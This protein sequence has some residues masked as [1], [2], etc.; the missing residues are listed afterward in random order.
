MYRIKRLIFSGLMTIMI[1]CLTIAGTLVTP[2][3]EQVRTPVAAETGD[4]TPASNTCPLACPWRRSM[5][6]DSW[7]TVNLT[8]SNFTEPVGVGSEAEITV[9]AKSRCDISNVTV[10]IVLSEAWP[11]VYPKGISF[12]DGSSSR[13]WMVNLQANISTSFTERIKAF[14]TGFG[15]IE[16]TARWWN[17]TPPPFE[18]LIPPWVT[19]ENLTAIPR[20]EI[21]GNLSL[22]IWRYENMSGGYPSIEALPPPEWFN[23]SIK[24]IYLNESIIMTHKNYTSHQPPSPRFLYESKDSSL[25]LV[26]NDGILVTEMPIPEPPVYLL[27][28]LSNFTEP[29]G[30]G[31]ET[32][33]TVFLI[34]LVD[35]QNVSAQIILPEGLSFISGNLTWSG[36]LKTNLRTRFSARIRAEKTGNWTIAIGTG[37]YLADG[38]WF[39]DAEVYGVWWYGDAQVLGISVYDA[40]IMRWSGN[41]LLSPFPIGYHYRTYTQVYPGSKSY[42]E[43]AAIEWSTD[44]HNINDTLTVE[45]RI[46]GVSDLA[47]IQFYVKWDPTV[48]R[49]LC[50]ESGDFLEALGYQSIWMKSEKEIDLG[51]I[52]ASHCLMPPIVSGVGITTPNSG[53]V[54]TLIFQVI[55]FTEGTEI[56][57]SSDPENSENYWLDSTGSGIHHDFEFMFPAHFSFEKSI[58]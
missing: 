22:G 7:L 48:L 57:F 3:P 18:T 10:Q 29:Q 50:I 9:V 51:Y 43:P 40:E 21:F 32:N 39:G 44:S 47:A 31:S 17:A 5:V 28:H 45:V 27:I 42:L 53:L 24:V 26:W 11:S 38:P 37:T 41:N 54:A 33:L 35:L 25:V 6:G 12:L 15:A 2:R 34:P 49:F 8:I 46:T 36:D 13:S 19:I 55:N 30:L 58:D 4:E 14:E 52:L 1:A 23:E 56:R 16:V 20:D